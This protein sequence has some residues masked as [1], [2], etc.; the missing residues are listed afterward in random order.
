MGEILGLDANVQTAL[1]IIVVGIIVPG[2]TALINNPK[3]PK[4]LRRLTP[5]ILSAAGAV[6]IVVLQAGGPFA[7]QLITILLVLATLVGIA[8]ALYSAMPS[9]WKRLEDATTT[10]DK[11]DLTR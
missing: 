8:Q 5:I 10:E 2:V 11:R 1:T 3:V 9:V 6:I 4:Q 7:E